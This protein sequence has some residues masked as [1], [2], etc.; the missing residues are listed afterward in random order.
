[1]A[2]GKEKKDW[3]VEEPGLP[4]TTMSFNDLTVTIWPLN[5]PRIKG[6]CKVLVSVTELVFCCTTPKALAY[7]Q[8]CQHRPQQIQH[9][10]CI[11]SFSS[12]VGNVC[13]FVH[14]ASSCLGMALFENNTS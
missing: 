1:M 2:Q 13:N 9:F 11:N 8:L 5:K 12:N 4:A 10:L 3:P 7:T 6:F 14:V